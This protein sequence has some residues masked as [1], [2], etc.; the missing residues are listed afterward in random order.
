MLVGQLGRLCNVLDA[1]VA[2]ETVELA[3]SRDI[4]AKH[5]IL[6]HSSSSA[7]LFIH[8]PET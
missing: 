1:V 3:G 7:R 8:L 5:G 4:D 2:S 6:L